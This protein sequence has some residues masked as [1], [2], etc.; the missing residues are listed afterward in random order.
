M[1]RATITIGGIS[2]PR[3]DNLD[4]HLG[5]TLHDRVKIVNFKPQQN[6]VSVGSI[7]SIADRTVMMFYVE[8]VQLKDE[9]AI[10]NQLLISSAAMI[11][12]TPKQPLVPFAACFHVRYRN[13]RL[14]AH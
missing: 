13:Q 7:V 4:A 5:G 14:R 9:F 11:A 10:R 6:A 2:M 12:S 3:H 1:I 8:A